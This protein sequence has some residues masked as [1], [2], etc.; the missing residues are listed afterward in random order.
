M[1]AQWRVLEGVDEAL[2]DGVRGADACVI[3]HNPAGIDALGDTTHTARS[4]WNSLRDTPTAGGEAWGALA[5][6]PDGMA[7]K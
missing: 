7:P 6:F 3:W 1:Q 5:R 2:R 4:A